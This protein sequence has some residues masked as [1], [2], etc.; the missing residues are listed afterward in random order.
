MA[1][2]S[3][4]LAW[5][6]PWTGASRATVHVIFPGNSTGEDCHFRLQQMF[7]TQGSNP[8]LPHCRETL[9]RQSHQGSPVSE[10]KVTRSLR[11]PWTEK[12]K[13]VEFSMSEY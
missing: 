7:P 8:G 4:I 5:K 1:T 13:S 11:P 2:H 10:V 3:R 9:Y 12:S 6:I